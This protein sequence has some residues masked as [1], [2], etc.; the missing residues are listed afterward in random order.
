MMA[1]DSRGARYCLRLAAATL[2][3]LVAVPSAAQ[4]Q[5]GWALG[6]RSAN[7]DPAAPESRDRRGFEAR[8]IYDREL[9]SRFG[10][11]AELGY[12]Q[13]QFQRTDS[14][15]FQV[16]ENGFEV[17]MQG[18]FEQR[19][20]ALTGLYA[21]VGPVASFRAACGSSGRFDPNGRVLC[22]AG[23]SYLTGVAAGLGYRWM[24]GARSDVTFEARYLDHV[25]AAN[26]RELF[27][28]AIGVRRRHETR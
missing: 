16:S 19:S 5:L 27:A 26:G 9:S 14:V 11:R 17:A 28:F 6:M 1:T 7:G 25:T 15:R 18:R 3:A 8:V 24:A 10:W 23:D 4:A 21:T 22:E 2:A 20:G 13:M 12:N